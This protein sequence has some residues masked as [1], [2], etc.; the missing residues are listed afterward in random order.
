MP[1]TTEL[2]SHGAATYKG[3]KKVFAMYQINHHGD[4]RVAL[5]LAA[6]PGAQQL[7]V[8]TEPKHYFVPPYVGPKGWLGVDLL[9]KLPWPR[10]AQHILDAYAAVAPARLVRELPEQPPK[11]KAPTK[12]PSQYEV[13]PMTH[14][15]TVK[16]LRVLA[17][18]CESLPET[19]LGQQF[20][21]PAWKAGK[22]TFA[23]AHHHGGRLKFSFWVGGERQSMLADDPRFRVPSYTGPNGWI[24][25][26]A[27]GTLD[28]EEVRYLAEESYRHFAL[29]RM[30]KALDG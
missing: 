19:S 16:R 4:G 28:G 10:V 17:D 15:D 20:G 2:I 30:L 11:I 1:E 29:K 22:K 9:S 5:W 21:N 25:L 7:H 12:L 14:P 18:V 3:A 6:P 26:D 23:T 27:E 8:E 13:A 24:E